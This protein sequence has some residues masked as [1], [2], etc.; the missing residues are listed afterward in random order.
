M[1]PTSSSASYS[2]GR[3]LYSDDCNKR[4]GLGNYPCNIDVSAIAGFLVGATEAYRT[5]GQDYEW[6]DERM[7]LLLNKLKDEEDDSVIEILTCMI[8]IKVA[9]RWSAAAD[10][11]IGSTNDPDDLDL[12]AAK[13]EKK[14][15]PAPS[16]VRKR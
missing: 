3:G 10:G 9:S 15:T 5:L 11:L 13:S 14:A 16:F 8:K 6:R 7:D 1:T 2:Y 12:L 4:S